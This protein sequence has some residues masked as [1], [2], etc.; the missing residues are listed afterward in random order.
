MIEVQEYGKALYE[1][2]E[3]SQ[4]SEEVLQE[5]EQVNA[6][7]VENPDYVKLMDSP[8]ISSD[9]KIKLIGD[10]FGDTQV[11]LLNFLK[12][13]CEKH[14]ICDFSGCMEAYRKIYQEE[15]GILTATAVTV[16]PL[17]DVQKEKLTEKLAA[18][19]G[20]KILLK[21]E[22]DPKLLGGISLQ[23]SGKQYD[24][25]LRA[26]LESFRKQLSNTIL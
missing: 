6:L 2:A 14:A 23:L 9:E 11:Y 21:N 12:I 16:S 7:F 8:A 10:A 13:L 18:I 25:S 15:K 26:R 24:A 3:E 5:M 17:S 4:L 22:I 19:T 1:L 20:K